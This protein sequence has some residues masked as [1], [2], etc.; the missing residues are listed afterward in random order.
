MRVMGVLIAILSSYLCVLGLGIMNVQAFNV[1]IIT[2]I[3]EYRNQITQYKE[4]LKA[5]NPSFHAPERTPLKGVSINNNHLTYDGY[6]FHIGSG[7]KQAFLI[8]MNGDTVHSWKIE[9]KKIWA[10]TA[11][12]SAHTKPDHWFSCLRAFLEPQ[13]GNIYALLSSRGA[14]LET[15]SLAQLDKNSDIIWVY[16]GFVHHD[17]AFS[18]DGKHLYVLGKKAIRRYNPAF[19]TL[20]PPFLDEEIIILDQQ[21]NEV[22]KISFLK[23]FETSQ[24]KGIIDHITAAP[25]DSTMHYGD[26]FHS[27]TIEV[28]PTKAIGKAPML[29]EGH[30]MISFRNLDLLAIVDPDKEEIT[31][32]SYGPWKGQHDPEIQNDGSVIMFDN[33]GS[34][35]K[36]SGASRILQV[37]LNTMAILW[38]YNGTKENPLSSA[39]NSSIHALPN[40]NI[41]ITETE[42]GRI[43]EVTRDKEIVW[44]YWNPK[45][46]LIEKSHH[47]EQ[48]NNTPHIPALFSA[49]RYSKEELKF[50]AGIQPR[51]IE[52]ASPITEELQ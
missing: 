10:D 19:P 49:I 40:S 52:N 35:K 33:Q 48:Y 41:L 14:A 4:D 34:L 1:L 22:K 30:L 38:E 45:R 12:H 20:A 46:I 29:K 21:G 23:L 37:D 32:A 16:Q 11:E 5:Y 43:F 47:G 17:L 39:Y 50:L 26:I 3:R 27:N 15:Y 2:P 28:I 25:A 51:Q 44:E 18:D 42:A 6:N 13:T 24:L 31:W 36:D 9:P 8:D 7:N